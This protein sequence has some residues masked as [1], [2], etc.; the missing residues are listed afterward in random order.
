MF[1]DCGVL[2]NEEGNYER[3]DYRDHQSGLSLH[4]FYLINWS[5]F[6]ALCVSLLTNPESQHKIHGM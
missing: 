4:S 2:L 6:G 5:S 1:L 3:P